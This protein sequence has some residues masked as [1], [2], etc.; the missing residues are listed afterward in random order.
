MSRTRNQGA[1]YRRVAI[2]GVVGLL[3]LSSVA[4]AAW[5]HA[6]VR[7]A[8]GFAS[9]VFQQQWSSVEAVIPNFWG[10]LSTARDGQIEPYVEGTAN[11]QTGQRLVQYFDKARMELTNPATGTVTNGLLA[12]ELKTGQLQLGNDSFQQ[13]AA[14]AIGIAGDPGAAGPT[15]ASLAQLP[16]KV[17]Q[18]NGSVNLGY[19]IATN[20]FVTTAP[21]ADPAAIFGAYISD[22]GGRF[23]QNVPQAFVD[24]LNRIPGGYLTVMGYPISPAFAA[25]VQVAGV[26]NVPVIVQAFQRKVLTYTASNPEAFKV[27]FGNIGQ[28]YYQWRY[29][30]GPAATGTTDN[31]IS[32]PSFTNVADTSATVVFTTNF[33][34]CGTAEY[35]VKGATDWTTNLSGITCSATSATTTQA[36]SLTGLSANTAYEVRPAVKDVTQTV[37]YGPVGAFT[38]AAASAT[39]TATSAATATPTPTA[40]ATPASES[41][42]SSPT[43]GSAPSP[44]P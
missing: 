8:S 28:H 26:P 2:G 21:S 7:A 27:E 36:I 5:W 41:P 25:N 30:G 31:L 11:G 34:A 9:P 17:P 35:R 4:M 44:R 6:D 22:P 42:T 32:A 19:D 29:G 38:T 16:E 14:A 20:T 24:F 43:P 1:T 18:A 33:P 37:S 13:R 40:T 3:L 12:V 15:Y 23:G 39:A 10:P